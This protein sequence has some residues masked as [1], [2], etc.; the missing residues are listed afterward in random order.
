M[1]KGG[2][3]PEISGIWWSYGLLSGNLEACS[4]ENTCTYAAYLSQMSIISRISVG[5]ST[6]LGSSVGLVFS[7]VDTIGI[8]CY[9]Y[10]IVKSGC[11]SR[12]LGVSIDILLSTSH[13]RP[14][15]ASRGPIS[16]TSASRAND[17]SSDVSFVFIEIVVLITYL[18]PLM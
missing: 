14:N 11:L 18:P 3:D 8:R 6:K 5:L 16:A 13:D 1:P 15:I 2:F 4:A 9:L 7:I 12:R 10:W 17:L